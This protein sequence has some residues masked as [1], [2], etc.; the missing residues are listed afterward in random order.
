MLRGS[1]SNTDSSS[2]ACTDSSPY[3][4]S[5]THS[6]THTGTHSSTNTGTHSS[7]H[8]GS[9][10]CTNPSTTNTRASSAELLGE[11]FQ[12]SQGTEPVPSWFQGTPGFDTMFGIQ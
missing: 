6:S 3:H 9:Y 10:S 2:Y 11:L 12:A 4:G 5:I 8:S 7:T 1:G